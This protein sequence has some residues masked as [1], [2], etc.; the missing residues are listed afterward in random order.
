MSFERLLWMR[1]RIHIHMHL[2]THA[3]ICIFSSIGVCWSVCLCTTLYACMRAC[4]HSCMGLVRKSVP[5]LCVWNSCMMQVQA[6]YSNTPAPGGRLILTRTA[7]FP[8]QRSQKFV[9]LQTVLTAHR[10]NS[11]FNSTQHLFFSFSDHTACS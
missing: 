9:D 4:T 10:L 11:K 3:C 5:A 7:N 6:I 2:F 1:A 8:T